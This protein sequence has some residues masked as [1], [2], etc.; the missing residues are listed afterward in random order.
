MPINKDSSYQTFISTTEL[1]RLMGVSRVAILKKIKTG[2]IHAQKV[3]RNYIIPAEEF[4]IAVGEFISPNKKV[5]IEEVVKKAV[6]EYRETLRLL[7]NE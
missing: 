4:A 1:A 2:K 7:G 5:E 6:K 3:G